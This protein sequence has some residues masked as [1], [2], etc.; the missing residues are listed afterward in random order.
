[1][2]R[3]SLRASFPI[4]VTMTCMACTS[5]DARTTETSS[6]ANPGRRVEIKATAVP[7][8]PTDPTQTAIGA[9][10]YV[11]GVELT[12]VDTTRLHGLSDLRIDPDGRLLAVGDEGDLLE[13]HVVLDGAGHL[14]GLSDA[15][16]TPLL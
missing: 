8:N 3:V 4:V 6:A 7:L 11:G 2:H 5:N 14:Q 12:S 15:R 1:M 9:F 16:L 13:A 10:R